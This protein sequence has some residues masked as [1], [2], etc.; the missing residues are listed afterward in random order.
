MAYHWRPLVNLDDEACVRLSP[1]T[2][3]YGKVL[4]ILARELTSAK[5]NVADLQVGRFAGSISLRSKAGI[6]K[7]R[8]K[9]RVTVNA[10]HD[11]WPGYSGPLDDVLV[12]EGKIVKRDT[13]WDLR[14][15]KSKNDCGLSVFQ[16]FQALCRDQ[17]LSVPSDVKSLHFSIK[18]GLSAL[19]S[20]P[21]GAESLF[22][23]KKGY[24]ARKLKFNS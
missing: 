19:E 9:G 24:E 18:D 3:S 16:Q 10:V 4:D 20:S 8:K 1:Y 2:E 14:D 22:E 5:R 15:L 13:P 12:V 17:S 23:H 11:S 7:R 21:D 6:Q